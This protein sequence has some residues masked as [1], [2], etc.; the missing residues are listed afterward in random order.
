MRTQLT[1]VRAYCIRPLLTA[2][3][4]LAITF[5]LS[6]SDDKDDGGDNP[7]SS[8]SGLGISS[9]GG[10]QLSGN[11][12]Y[13]QMK[14]ELKYYDP[15]DIFF[16]PPQRCQN[17]VVE[18]GCEMGGEVVWYNPLTHG[19]NEMN[20]TTTC[21]GGGCMTTSE[22]EL[23][24]LELCGSELYISSPNGLRRCKGGILEG[25]CGFGENDPWYNL[26]TH[27]C[28]G[29]N[30]IYTLKAKE[31]CGNK[32]YISEESVIYINKYR[33]QNEIL[34]GKCGYGENALWY[35][36]ET[37]YCDHANG[38]VKANE[39][40]GNKY[41]EFYERCNNGIVEERC[42]SSLNENAPYYNR[43]TQSCNWMD[44]TIK[45]KERCG[46]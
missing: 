43:L 13:E 44:V 45:A 40:C 3:L 25:K 6:C 9:P 14:E 10:G 42:G 11:P 1:D 31:R 12:E 15:D 34:E 4:A 30:S 8:S 28:E 24:T 29:I 18:Y 22:M 27:Y 7:Q 17:G 20:S 21:E 41:L 32:Y 37:H 39:R 5:T 35:N 36:S 2:I 19:C 26:E 16:R 33:C 23:G 46:G 38:T